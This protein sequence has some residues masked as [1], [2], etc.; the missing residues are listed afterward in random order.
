MDSKKR[1]TKTTRESKKNL[2]Y[3]DHK[4]VESEYG[5]G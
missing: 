3:L 4:V 1:D 5:L 2:E